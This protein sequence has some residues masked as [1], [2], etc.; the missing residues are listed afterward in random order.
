M[1]WNFVAIDGF[2]KNQLDVSRNIQFVGYSE[3]NTV[4]MF[5]IAV[6]DSDGSCLS[7]CL[8]VCLSLH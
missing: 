6:I 3:K 2:I 7:V 5:S 1:Y 4:M 8:S